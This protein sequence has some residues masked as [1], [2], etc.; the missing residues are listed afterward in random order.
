[1]KY[2]V[3]RFLIGLP[4]DAGAQAY[5]VKPDFDHLKPTIDRLMLRWGHI[6]Y[7]WLLLCRLRRRLLNS[8]GS[9][10]LLRQCFIA[11]SLLTVYD[12]HGD[13]YCGGDACYNQGCDRNT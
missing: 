8:G 13:N 10:S 5:L 3:S 6:D 4:E 2:T 1:M 9:R 12:Q 7:Y 11:V